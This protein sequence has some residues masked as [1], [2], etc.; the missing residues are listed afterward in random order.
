MASSEAEQGKLKLGVT[1][2]ASHAGTGGGG[3][4]EK[5]KA[6]KRSDFSLRIWVS[7]LCCGATVPACDSIIY[8][9]IHL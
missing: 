7:I 1:D 2:Q 5:K 9:Q 8:K 3:E 4:G 6:T